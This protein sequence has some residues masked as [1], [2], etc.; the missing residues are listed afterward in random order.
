VD[1]A[2]ANSFAA[3]M[4]M[5]APQSP[6]A[7]QYAELEKASELLPE[8]LSMP[9]RKRGATSFELTVPRQGVALLVVELLRQ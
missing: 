6:N 7:T 9:V 5:G 1:G 4:K 8:S 3:W 2:H